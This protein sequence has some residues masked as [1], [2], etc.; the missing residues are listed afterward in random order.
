M[1]K[2]DSYGCLL[3][4]D[5][6]KVPRIIGIVNEA[7]VFLRLFLMLR[8]TQSRPFF[9]T[10]NGTVPKWA[11]VIFKKASSGNETVVR[12]QQQTSVSKI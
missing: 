8:S 6:I 12:M 4:L 1:Q 5:F 7:K 10:V 2:F 11:I 3:S 9:P